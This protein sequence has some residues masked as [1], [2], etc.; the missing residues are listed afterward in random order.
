MNATS[1]NQAE[2]DALLALPKVK[3]DEKEWR[4]DGGKVKLSI[5]L[6]SQ[7]KRENYLLDIERRQIKL[8]GKYQTRVRTTIILARLDFGGAPHRNPDGQDI[9]CPHLHLYRE[10]YGDGW[11][12]PVPEV[13]F[14]DLDDRWKLLQDFMRYCNIVD[15]PK[16]I[17]GL[18]V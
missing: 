1:L 17:R 9:L 14:P 4:Y 7:D 15:P 16:I 18:Y 2:A 13:H 6:L 3:E 10:G 11:A 12:I 8:K 5:P